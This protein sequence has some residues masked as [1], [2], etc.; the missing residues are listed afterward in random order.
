MITIK[1]LAA[2]DSNKEKKPQHKRNHWKWQEGEAEEEEKK[3]I[4]KM[5][6]IPQYKLNYG[7][8]EILKRKGLNKKVENANIPGSIPSVFGAPYKGAKMVT[9]DIVTFVQS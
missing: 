8:I 1:L 4:T 7:S 9:F 6:L 2:V 3:K 5:T